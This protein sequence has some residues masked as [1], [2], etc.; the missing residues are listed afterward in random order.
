MMGSP[1][2]VGVGE[3]GSEGM[4]GDSAGTVSTGGSTVGAVTEPA[5]RSSEQAVRGNA[6]YKQIPTYPE[7]SHY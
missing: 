7:R 5:G 4:A 6:G 3:G 2:G 1:G